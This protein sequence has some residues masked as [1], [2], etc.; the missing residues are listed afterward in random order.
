[1]RNATDGSP[2]AAGELPINRDGVAV[3]RITTHPAGG[4][5]PTH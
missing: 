5:Q 2:F 4:Q 3:E 1:M